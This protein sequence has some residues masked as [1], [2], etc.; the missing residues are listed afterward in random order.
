MVFRLDKKELK[1]IFGVSI[2]LLLWFSVVIPE[3]I[4]KSQSN[5]LLTYAIFLVIYGLFTMFFI[6]GINPLQNI[7]LL[8][9]IIIIWFAS[10]LI[11]PPILISKTVPTI[12]STEA[13]FS[14]D[15]IVYTLLSNLLN[16]TNPKTLYYLVYVVIPIALLVVS[17]FIIQRKK[18]TE[19]LK[20]SV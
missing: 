13:Q 7:R 19:F 12:L 15:Y 4:L 6:V 14:T 8:V 1:I 16:I 18:F 2:F 20:G 17:A 3:L 10:D 11:F 5:L 9:G